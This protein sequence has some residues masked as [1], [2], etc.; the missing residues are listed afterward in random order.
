MYVFCCLSACSIS[1]HKWVFFVANPCST[2]TMQITAMLASRMKRK[3]I[4]LLWSLYITPMFFALVSSAARLVQLIT[5]GIFGQLWVSTFYVL[6]LTGTMVFWNTC[7]LFL[8]ALMPIWMTMKNDADNLFDSRDLPLPGVNLILQN[9]FTNGE[10]PGVTTKG[11]VLSSGGTFWSFLLA[12][13][14]LQEACV[15][16]LCKV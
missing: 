14:I 16:V 2:R 11:W 12:T 7:T 8:L 15:L 3:S 10:L 6:I 13:V 4:T 9:Y 1:Y 5:S